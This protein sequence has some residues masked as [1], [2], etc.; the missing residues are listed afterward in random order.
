[1]NPND[2]VAAD[3]QQRALMEVS[4]EAL[5]NGKCHPTFRQ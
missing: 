4:Y 2:A 3:P 5:Q 1:M